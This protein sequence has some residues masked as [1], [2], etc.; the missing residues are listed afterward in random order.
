MATS[1][2]ILI[3][4][5]VAAMDN[6]YLNRSAVSGSDIDNG[7]IFNLQSQNATV[8]M[9]EVFDAI[10]PTTG[11]L[12]GLWMACAPEIVTVT[13][14]ANKYRGIDPDPRNFY[15]SASTVFDAFKPMPGDI[16][17]LT[18]DAL[19]SATTAAFAVATVTSFKWT[20]AAAPAGTSVACLRYLSTNYISMGMSGSAV[21]ATQRAT[22]YKFE[23]LYN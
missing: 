22:S 14:G 2:A 7:W 15:T 12:I 23:V 6:S 16:I 3:Q 5:K 18:A 19:D 21:G 8:G 9:T 20:W 11:S 17:T 1:H 13:S 4:N 10:Q